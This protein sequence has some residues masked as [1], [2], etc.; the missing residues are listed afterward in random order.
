MFCLGWSNLRTQND[1]SIRQTKHN[2]AIAEKRVGAALSMVS[3]RYTAQ[4]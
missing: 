2:V 1:D 4:Q 3:P